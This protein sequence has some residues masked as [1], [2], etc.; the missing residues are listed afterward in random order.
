V[1]LVTKEPKESASAQS[2]G[3]S[4]IE[5]IRKGTSHSTVCA[6]PGAPEEKFWM[7]V[8]L[9]DQI[10]EAQAAAVSRWAKVGLELNLYTSDDFYS[11]MSMQLLTRA[12]RV[13]LPEDL[14]RKCDRLFGTAD[15]LRAVL[16]PDERT[17]L[18]TA[19]M[20]NQEHA[21]PDPADMN[22]ETIENLRE[23]VKKKD[24]VLLSAF[25]SVTLAS[26]IIGT[27]SRPSS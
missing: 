10:Q 21:N 17:M 16:E 11:E 5:R 14:D 23:A 18:F 27:A 13:H 24:V 4:L 8:L 15:E 25:G 22:A 3:A 7:C 9:C 1:P 6:W 20:E 19:Y 26:F 2:A 12:M